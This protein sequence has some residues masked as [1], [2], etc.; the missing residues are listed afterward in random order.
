GA[1][2]RRLARNVRSARARQRWRETTLSAL[3]ACG[4]AEEAGRLPERY[5]PLIDPREEIERRDLRRVL[6]DELHQLPEKYRAP[7][8]LCDLEGRTHE[9]A[10][11]QL[12]WP[13][14][15]MSRRLDRARRLLRR[16]LTHRGVALAIPVLVIAAVAAL[17]SR[18]MSDRDHRAGVDGV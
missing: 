2:A 10:A 14:G 1:V 8:V 4:T 9:E 18:W 5:H 15:S 6:D 7:V 13:A 16:R 3:A 12:G 17:G 11:R